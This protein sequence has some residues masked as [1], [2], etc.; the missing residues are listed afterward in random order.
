[1]KAK[2]HWERDQMIECLPP[3]YKALSSNP[4]TAK[5]K[6]DKEEK[7]GKRVEKEHCVDFG[8]TGIGV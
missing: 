8:C 1:M 3:N 7:R 5:K 6:L 2:K 4:N